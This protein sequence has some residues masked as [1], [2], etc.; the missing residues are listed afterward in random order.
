[1]GHAR[2]AAATEA[3]NASHHRRAKKVR[4][5]RLLWQLLQATAA[6]GVP[7]V[8]ACAILSPQQANLAAARDVA[9]AYMYADAALSVD[10]CFDAHAMA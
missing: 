9:V 6:S 7:T 8:W 1:M 4:D 5:R 2:A 3:S 10:A